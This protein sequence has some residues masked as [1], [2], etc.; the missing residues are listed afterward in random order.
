MATSTKR[1]SSNRANN[2]NNNRGKRSLLR[3][4]HGQKF[5]PTEMPPSFVSQ[6]WNNIQL[7]LRKRVSTSLQKITIDDMR[8]G[9]RA[10]C[11]FSNV[12]DSKESSN[13][14]VHFDI[15]VKNISVWAT[16]GNPMSLF[17][18]DTFNATTELCR[19]DSNPQRNMYARAGYKLPL[20]QS[21]R[22]FSSYRDGATAVFSV[23]GAAAYEIHISLLWKGADTAMPTLQYVYPESPRKRKKRDLIA[24]L[25][26]LELE[27]SCEEEEFSIPNSPLQTS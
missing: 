14:N 17:P 16:D 7:I 3:E 22:T 6:P 18:M 10:Q 27:D 23:V 26:E 5:L 15:R 9:L 2:N 11:G 8:L 21:S 1:V 24:L 19:I 25:R 4:M 20:A 13:S 12:P